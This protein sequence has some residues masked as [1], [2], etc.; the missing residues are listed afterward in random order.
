MWLFKLE[1]KA[2]TNK[3]KFNFPKQP[4]HNPAD[5]SR[6]H[7]ISLFSPSDSHYKSAMESSGSPLA[8]PLSPTKCLFET[9]AGNMLLRRSSLG[10]D[11]PSMV[12]SH[13]KVD[14]SSPSPIHPEEPPTCKGS[15]ATDLIGKQSGE[16]IDF[17]ELNC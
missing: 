8:S 12:Q 11:M 3:Q 7:S 1:G 16:F 15:P 13:G 17:I 10:D 9:S 6:E 5:Q 2:K 4:D 14:I